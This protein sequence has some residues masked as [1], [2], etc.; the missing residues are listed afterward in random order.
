ME[1]EVRPNQQGHVEKSLLVALPGQ[2][3][4]S[5]LGVVNKFYLYSSKVLY[6]PV[7]RCWKG[8]RGLEEK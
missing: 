4:Y 7:P 8:V 2:D 5:H 1:Q 6:V 3:H